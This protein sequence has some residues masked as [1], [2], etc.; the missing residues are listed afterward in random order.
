M[1][2]SLPGGAWIAAGL[3][4]AALVVPGV[5]YATASLTEITGTNGTTPANVTPAHQLFTATTAPGNAVVL[6]GSASLQSST[7]FSFRMPATGKAIVLRDL[8]TSI[9]SGGG[10]DI[11][12][13]SVDPT[14]CGTPFAQVELQTLG[15]DEIT[16][17]PGIPVPAGDRVWIQLGHSSDVEDTFWMDADGYTVPNAAV[18]QAPDVAVRPL[19][20]AR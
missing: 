6:T 10:A 8:R 14:T 11:V 3:V 1:K 19:V 15:N 2:R 4:I 18:A 20:H 16:F 9:Q 5:T 13:V 7:C 17:D 12:F